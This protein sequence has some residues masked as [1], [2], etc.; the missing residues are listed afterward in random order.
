ME[1]LTP[2]SRATTRQRSS[3]KAGSRVGSVSSELVEAR[4]RPTMEGWA[5]ALWRRTLRSL[6]EV[7]REG[8]GVYTFDA[9]NAFPFEQ[10][11]QG[12]LAGPVA[13]VGC[14]LAD[15]D[16]GGL[17]LA[18]FLVAGDHTIVAYERVGEEQ[19]LPLV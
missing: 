2:K 4:S 5:C 7:P 15:Q 10:V 3:A 9:E 16:G 8:T 6:S 19:D 18:G 17:N 11:G 12:L 14:V 1:P 13:R